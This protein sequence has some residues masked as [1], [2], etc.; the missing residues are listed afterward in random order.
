MFTI[1][2]NGSTLDE[3]FSNVE[4]FLMQG[5]IPT[6]PVA[7]PVTPATPQT[8]VS[9]PPFQQPNT[10]APTYTLDQL[11]RA[12]AS[13]ARLGNMEQALALLAKNNIQTVSQLKPEQY[14]EFAAELRALGAQVL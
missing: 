9:P 12:G 10:A 3:L 13:L 11:A 2:I 14:G 4:A 5:A 7:P 8:M 1:T 6:Q